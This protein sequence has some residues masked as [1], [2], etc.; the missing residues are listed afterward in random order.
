MTRDYPLD[1]ECNVNAPQGQHL[2]SCEAAVARPRSRRSKGRGDELENWLFD[3]QAH[4]DP[5]A[6][7]ARRHGRRQVPDFDARYAS[8]LRAREGR[9]RARRAA[10]A[11]S[12]TPTFF[13]NGVRIAGPDRAEFFDAAIALRAEAG[14][15][16][17]V[18]RSGQFGSPV[19]RPGVAARLPE[20]PSTDYDTTNY[21]T[22]CRQ[23]S[24]PTSSPRTIAVGFWRKRPYRA[25][26]P[27]DARRRSR[28]RSSASSGPNGAGKTTTLKLLM[29]LIFPTAGAAAILGR[30]VGD[31]DVRRR[32]GYLPEN[33]YFYDYLTAEELLRY[34]AGLF[35]FTGAE[36]RAARLGAARRRR[37]RRPSG[38]CSSASSRRA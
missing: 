20:L 13:V 23:R 17:Q 1:P 22:S 34:F 4:A 16:H 37:H 35:G 32:I 29:Q 14:R 8:T 6:R 36:R 25:A 30:P 9:R 24:R 19:G 38:G 27:P 11:C 2:A 33:P 28:A 15:G 10:A 31:L 12:G 3:N 21:R 7:A 26:R 18:V 5:G